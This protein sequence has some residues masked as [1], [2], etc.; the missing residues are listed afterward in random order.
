M[1]LPFGFLL[2]LLSAAAPALAQPAAPPEAPLGAYRSA[3]AYRHRRPALTGDAIRFS[4]KHN[5][6]VV[7]TQRGGSTFRQRIARDSVWGYVDAQRRLYRLQGPDDYRVEQADTL[8]IYSRNATTAGT[9]QIT[10]YR[11]GVGGSVYTTLHY[12]FG[13]GLMGPI[14]PLTDKNLREA[15]QAASPAFVAAVAQRPAGR[16]LF[17]YDPK[18]QAFYLVGQFRATGGK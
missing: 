8:T 18:A 2:G 14:Y 10:G 3:A 11:G 6:F 5:E 7:S 9:D 1:R 15:Y 17:A 16:E 4:P 12:Y 13:R